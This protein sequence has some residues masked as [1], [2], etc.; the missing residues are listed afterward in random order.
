MFESVAERGVEG[1]S[2]REIARG[3]GISAGSLTHH[4]PNKQ[5]LLAAASGYGLIRPPDEFDHMAPDKMLDWLISRY[6]LSS[7]HRATWW[8]FWLAMT[9]H[10]SVDQDAESRVAE[11]QRLIV[12]LWESCLKRRAAVSKKA[13]RPEARWVAA[14]AHGL[15]LQQLAD[16]SQTRWAEAALKRLVGSDKA[17]LAVL[18]HAVG[19]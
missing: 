11:H 7:A 1:T 12:E 3:L 19:Q 5:I 9:I 6:V 13:L 14:C 16:P 2:V 10:A 18:T 17:N 8:R 15:A 4:F